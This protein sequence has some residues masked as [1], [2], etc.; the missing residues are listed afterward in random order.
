MIDNIVAL[1]FI[2]SVVIAVFWGLLKLVTKSQKDTKK[3]SEKSNE[4]RILNT[5]QKIE[6]HAFGIKIGIF[7]ILIYVSVFRN[8]IKGLL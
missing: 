2:C 4:E 3:E 8:L 5:L 1:I 7:I 6:K